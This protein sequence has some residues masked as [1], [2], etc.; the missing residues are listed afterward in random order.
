MQL[1]SAASPRTPQN[2]HIIMADSEFEHDSDST[3]PSD[4]EEREEIIDEVVRYFLRQEL[5]KHERAKARVERKRRRALRR[6][7][8]RLVI[9]KDPEYA[10]SILLDCFEA[11]QKSF[12]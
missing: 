12:V 9:F 8:E 7:R 3:T 6:R 11:I 10:K 1:Y 5:S 2:P 4:N